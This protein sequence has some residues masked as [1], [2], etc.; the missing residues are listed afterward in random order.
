MFQLQ[1]N[2]YLYTGL[3]K[4]KK[5]GRKLGGKNSVYVESLNSIND[6]EDEVIKKYGT[7]SRPTRKKHSSI[8][9]R[10]FF[11][12]QPDDFLMFSFYRNHGSVLLLEKI[13]QELSQTEILEVF[14]VIF[15]NLMNCELLSML[16]DGLTL[17]EI[18]KK[19]IISFSNPAFAEIFDCEKKNLLARSIAII[20]HDLFVDHCLHTCKICDK[21]FEYETF[22]CTQKCDTSSI[23]KSCLNDH[24]EIRNQNKCISCSAEYDLKQSLSIIDQRRFFERQYASSISYKRIKTN[25]FICNCGEFKPKEASSTGFVECP[26]CKKSLC[27]ACGLNHLVGFCA[28]LINEALKDLDTSNFKPC[29][30]CGT[31]IE[32]SQGCLHIKCINCHEFFC[33]SCGHIFDLL[34]YLFFLGIDFCAANECYNPEVKWSIQMFYDYLQWKQMNHGD[35]KEIFVF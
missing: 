10:N 22:K 21:Q 7:K 35:E 8:L 9:A 4:K 25:I 28:L 15:P 27:V 12:S 3:T 16:D 32:K 29:P 19:Y 33:F 18:L 31:I 11:S 17:I 20:A 26:Q 14:R 30:H 24:L 23:C 13:H 34:I 2:E 1:V 6:D 5:R